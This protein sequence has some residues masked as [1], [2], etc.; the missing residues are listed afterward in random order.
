MWLS[1]TLVFSTL[2]ILS[3]VG[4]SVPGLARD[5]SSWVALITIS[6]GATQAVLSGF[7]MPYLAQK[8]SSTRYVLTIAANLLWNII[9]LAAVAAIADWLSVSQDHFH[10]KLTC[11]GVNWRRC[12]TPGELTRSVCKN[13]QPFQL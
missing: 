5:D 3:Q 1:S 6:I 12:E 2:S 11:S 7:V 10:M 9:L 13:L 8:L 4:K